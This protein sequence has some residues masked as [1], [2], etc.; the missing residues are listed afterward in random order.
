MAEDYSVMVIAWL[1]VLLL[2]G[3]VLVNA[4]VDLGAREFRR[5]LSDRRH[6]DRPRR[7]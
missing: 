1:F 5:W 6:A 4:A 2:G 3:F 7:G